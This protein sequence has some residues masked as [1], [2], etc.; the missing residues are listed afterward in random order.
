MTKSKKLKPMSSLSFRL[1]AWTMSI[2]D[3]F[4]NPKQLLKK[5]PFQKGMV[6]VDYACG[7]GRY[8]I[9]AAEI[10]GPKGKVYAVDI[11]PVAIEM[12]KKK[13]KNKSLSNVETVL[14]DS[15]NTGIP[16]SSADIVLLIDAIFP[17]KDRES[18]FKEIYRLLKPSGWLFMDPSHLAPSKAK[19]LVENMGLFVITEF[20]GRNMLLKKKLSK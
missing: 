12:V 16:D 19:S 17:I 9:P 4:S 14:V 10:I 20:D 8:T 18:L 13:A 6:V 1:M 15:F 2:M 7:P 3:L 11:Q 5:V